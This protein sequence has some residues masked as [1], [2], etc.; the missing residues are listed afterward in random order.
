MSEKQ[1]HRLKE[2]IDN[3]AIKSILVFPTSGKPEEAVS[4]LKSLTQ[5]NN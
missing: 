2:L 4:N 3:K 5:I 1:F